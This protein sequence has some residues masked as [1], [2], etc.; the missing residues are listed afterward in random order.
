MRIAGKTRGNAPCTVIWK[1]IFNPGSLLQL[2]PGCDQVE[3]VSSDQYRASLTLHVP[4]LAGNYAIQIQV[5]DS[6]EPQFCRLSGNA[7]GPG[8]TIQGTG[9]VTL[10]PQ[11]QKTLIQYECEIQISGPLA[12]MHPRFVEGVAQTLIRQG[13]TKLAELSRSQPQP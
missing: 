2:I 9:S 6:N 7:R 8:G 13:L 12:G 4:A 1:L 11:D 5:M 10:L 3:Q